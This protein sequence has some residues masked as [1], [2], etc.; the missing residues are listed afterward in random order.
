MKPRLRLLKPPNRLA[1]L[2]ERPG[3]LPRGVAIAR[4]EA[5]L[6]A[7][8]GAAIEMIAIFITTL[9]TMVARPVPPLADICRVTDRLIALAMLYDLGG[10]AE[11]GKRLCD[12]AG[13]FAVSG[14]VHPG[15]LAVHVQALRLLALDTPPDGVLAGL[16][17][18]LA[19]FGARRG[20]Q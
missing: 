11:A 20:D 13:A 7:Q 3:G 5:R 14:E 18:V 10:L 4:A 9:E 12:L 8:R 16:D 15:S 19:H 1:P 17:K 6:E 2:V